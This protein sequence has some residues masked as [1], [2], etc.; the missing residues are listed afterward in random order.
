[1]SKKQNLSFEKSLEK[2]E[3]I[4]EAAERGDVPLEDFLG[5]YEEGMKHLLNCREILKKME[6]RIEK[7]NAAERENN[8]EAFET[9]EE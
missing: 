5:K 2:L 6:L 7:L 3:Q 1:M 8:F 4:V 9:P